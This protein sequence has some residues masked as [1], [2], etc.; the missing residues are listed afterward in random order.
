MPEIAR[1]EITDARLHGRQYSLRVSLDGAAGAP[2]AG[3]V[4]WEA[5]LAFIVF[6]F[7]CWMVVGLLPWV[8]CA[9]VVRGRGALP[10]LPLALG[11]AA[12]A[13]VL[14]P[15]IGLRDFSGFLI[16]LL[17]AVIGGAAGAVAGV[18][19]DRYM[20]RVRPAKAQPVTPRHIGKR[21][22]GR[23]PTSRGQ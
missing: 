13:G 2:D 12:A 18:V 8:I 11:G 22:P 6:F 4:I 14:V 17:T 7:L 19:F 16:S 23:T 9:V 10:A 1:R 21:R 3:N 15:A 5:R 20:Q